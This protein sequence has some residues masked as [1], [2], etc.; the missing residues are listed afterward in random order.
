M[1]NTLEKK[2]T[3][4]FQ[5]KSLLQDALRHRSA[6]GASNERLEFLGDAILNFIIASTLYAK[7]PH[8]TEGELSR[9][10]A[11]LVKGETLA[12]LA[13]EFDLNKYI[14]LGP[15]EKHL[16]GR[17]IIRKSIL[18]DAMEAIVGAIYLDAGITICQRC[19]LNWYEDQL[20]KPLTQQAQKDA[21]S[22][23]Q[24]YLQ[25]RQH[26]LPRYIILKIEGVSHHQRFHLR[27]EV[28]GFAV[29]TEGKGSNRREAEQEAAEL[30]LQALQVKLK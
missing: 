2:L 15:S 9:L 22:R 3:H 6:R 18:A 20:N 26:P 24:E 28:E 13:K 11:N 30:F 10:R 27:C 25:G 14:E 12:I 5:N 4:L 17:M 21:K 23:L 16:A 7:Y 19:V 8:V 29:T 1:L